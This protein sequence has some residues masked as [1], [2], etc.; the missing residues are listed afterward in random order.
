MALPNLRKLLRSTKDP[1]ILDLFEACA[2]ASATLENLSRETPRREE[3]VNEYEQL[4][5]DLKTEVVT[6]L[7][8]RE[9]D[10]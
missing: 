9:P 7:L 8:L 6:M 10:R 4:C 5:R 1:R 3:L 2:L